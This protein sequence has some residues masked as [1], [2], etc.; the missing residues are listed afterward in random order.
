MFD[1]LT[2]PACRGQ[3]KFSACTGLVP[4]RSHCSCD[5]GRV[6][7]G[8][9]TDPGSSPKS[10][11]ISASPAPRFVMAGRPRRSKQGSTQ[12]TQR[13]ANN[14][15]DAGASRERRYPYLTGR[16]GPPCCPPGTPPYSRYLRPFASFALTLAFITCQARWRA[17]WAYV[18]LGAENTD[19]RPP[20]WPGLTRPSATGNQ[21]R[22]MLPISNHPMKMTGSSPVMTGLDHCVRHVNSKGGW[23]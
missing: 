9:W 3:G 21:L 17:N 22:T 11:N 2:R 8:G 4:I 15:N 13:A 5:C 12:K 16:A 7:R 23:Y 1:I 18:I 14:A 20:S 19:S 6:C 10:A